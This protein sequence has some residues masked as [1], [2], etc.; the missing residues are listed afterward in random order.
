MFKKNCQN[1][2]A[3]LDKTKGGIEQT[4]LRIKELVNEQKWLDWVQKYA[5]QVG[6]L[7]TWSEVKKK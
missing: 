7:V 2:N 1:L 5:V 3:E 6:E 4:W